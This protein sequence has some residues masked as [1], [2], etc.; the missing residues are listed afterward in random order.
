MAIYPY[1]TRR[2]IAFSVGMFGRVQER[3]AAAMCCV[4]CD[5]G[6]P[7]RVCAHISQI[8]SCDAMTN[9]CTFEC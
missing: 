5:T 9:F 4:L 8:A 6:T 7:T 3:C 1:D 2:N